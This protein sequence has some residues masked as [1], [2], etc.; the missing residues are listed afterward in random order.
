M[1]QENN[2][3]SSYL[4]ALK[5]S[6]E[7]TAAASA[8]ALEARAEATN[9]GGTTG[10][11]KSFP[12][13]E[14]RRSPRYKCE[15]NIEICEVGCDVRTW[16]VFTDISMHGCYVE[17]QATFPVGMLLKMKLDVN[18]RKIEAK[19]NV[20]VS[21]P[22]L[23]MGIA[24]GEMS[25][26][27][28]ARLKELLTSISRPSVIMG[29]GIASSLPAQGA[30]QSVPLISDHAAAVQALIDFFENRQML[31]RDDFLRVLRQSQK[32]ST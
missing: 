14:K 21:Y 10:A 1:A 24:F 19:G 9:D 3:G 8:P 4:M 13:G 5:R 17:T 18:G 25:E 22:N 23:G 32:R 12:G 16:T 28:R 11:Q 2:D 15:G 20:R 7:P 30:L 26:E 31:M 6:S 29:P 27:N